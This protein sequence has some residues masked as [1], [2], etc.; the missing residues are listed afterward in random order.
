ME[1]NLAK[2]IKA[3]RNVRRDGVGLEGLDAA[4]MFK[5]VEGLEKLV[6]VVAIYDPNQAREIRQLVAVLDEVA[7][8][9]QD[10]NIEDNM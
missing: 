1:L 4:D 9:V 3:L 8:E 7:S 10:I 2:I 5:V 6:S